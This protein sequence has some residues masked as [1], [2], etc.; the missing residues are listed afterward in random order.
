ML[1]LEIC[2]VTKAK[3][4]CS[5]S[6]VNLFIARDLHWLLTKWQCYLKYL[7]FD[8]LIHYLACNQTSYSLNI[9]QKAIQ[10]QW[11]CKCHVWSTQKHEYGTTTQETLTVSTADTVE[12][13][14]VPDTEVP[15]T[16]H[17]N[18][19]NSDIM[20]STL[21]SPLVY[22]Y[23]YVCEYTCVCSYYIAWP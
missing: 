3:Q 20:R 6:F 17:L 13:N 18:S 15:G 7:E 23:V 5:L 14:Y 9:R 22:W 16:Y 19:F 10:C 12:S 8:L 1:K 4:T 21:L 2:P 11:T